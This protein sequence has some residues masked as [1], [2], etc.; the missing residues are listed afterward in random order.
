MPGATS[1]ND[2]WSTIGVK[3]SASS[4]VNEI[5]RSLSGLID[6]FRSL[7]SIVTPSI[8]IDD[9]DIRMAQKAVNSLENDLASVD[10]APA[11]DIDD[12]DVKT[13]QKAVNNLKRDI[14]SADAK[15]IIVD[16]DTADIASANASIRSMGTNYK[17]VSSGIQKAENEQEDFNRDLKAGAEELKACGRVYI[18]DA[19]TGETDG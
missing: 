12:A 10:V 6:T 16:V 2:V 19:E 14:I 13:A 1:N 8:D 7:S 15:D 3:D 11:I 18:L 4:V 9:T 5:T 17:D